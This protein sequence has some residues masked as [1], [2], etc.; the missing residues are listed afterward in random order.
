MAPAP[1]HE[2]RS[3]SITPFININHRI[4]IWM[5]A[6]LALAPRLWLAWQPTERLVT[7][8]L[9][10]DAYI[11]FVV[12]RNLAT[13]Y[14]STF[15][16]TTPG[17]GYHPLWLWLITPLW[18]FAAGDTPVR[19]ALTVGSALNVACIPLIYQLGTRLS[20]RRAGLVAAVLFALTPSTIFISV[21]GM[22]TSLVLFLSLATLCLLS[23]YTERPQYRS[24]FALGICS[25]LMLLARTDSVFLFA[26]VVAYACYTSPRQMR[27]MSVLV[28]CGLAGLVVS[29]WLAWNVLRFGTMLQSSAS[30]YPFALKQSGLYANPIA[31]LISAALILLVGHAAILCAVP[32]GIELRRSLRGLGRAAIIPLTIPCAAL[33]ALL[34]IHGSLRQNPQVY[35]FALFPAVLPLSIGLLWSR[36]PVGDTRFRVATT[37]IVTLFLISAAMQLPGLVSGRYPF[38]MAELHAAAWTSQTPADTKIGTF[39]AGIVAYY[40]SRPVVE[41]GGVFSP[42][43]YEALR[44]HELAAYARREGVVYLADYDAPLNRIYAPFLRELHPLL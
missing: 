11:Y 24:L 33:C 8:V 10:D 6:A 20:G 41:L 34:I 23:A 1:D 16:G 18:Q 3:W 7:V 15:D 39:N 42:S 25:G 44:H 40:G 28:T 4:T 19:L 36:R 13:G 38:Q 29:P 31:G 37:L 43:A 27:I 2:S 30:A 5:L 22:E 17:N 26:G 9:R 14:G 35:Y 32:L 21:N 12:A